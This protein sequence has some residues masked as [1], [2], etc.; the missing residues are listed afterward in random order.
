MSADINRK[1]DAL[2][3]DLDGTLLDI[4]IE[5]FI[6]AYLKA[7]AKKFTDHID[8]D[9]FIG[10]IFGAT[11]LMVQNDDPSRVNRAVFYEDFC[12]RLGLSYEQIEPIVEDFYRHDFPELSCWGRELPT[13][14]QIIKAARQKNLILVLATN[15]I[16]PTTAVLQRLEW[17][18]LSAHDFDLVTTMDNMH[19]CKPNPEYYREI[20]NFID[21][22]P[23]LCLMAGNDT[24]EDLSAEKAGMD[25]FL[26][27]DNILHRTTEEP[28]CSYRGSLADLADFIGKL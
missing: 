10:H 22:S 15:P 16:F 20:S 28:I 26:V 13:A 17:G 19:F 12:H 3:L 4:D 23:K 8:R 27:E 14:R 24:L 5:Q 21:C 25:T 11:S 2:L 1:Y 18:K 6:P 7:L 9:D